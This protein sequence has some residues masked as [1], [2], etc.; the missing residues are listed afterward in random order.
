LVTEKPTID[1]QLRDDLVA[2]L[3]APDGCPWDR[4]QRLTDLRAYLLEEAHEVASAID[5]ESWNDL[6]EEMGDLLFQLAFLGRL[7]EEAG[8]F[9]LSDSISTVHDKMVERHPHVFASRSTSGDQRAPDKEAVA[10]DWERR[11]VEQ[12]R[13]G[14]SLL[15]GVNPSLPSLLS[16]YRM[17]QKA[18]GV[19]FDWSRADDVIEKVREELAELEEARFES[20]ERSFEEIGDLLFAVANLARHL[21]VDP[22]A[23]LARSNLKFRRRFGFIEKTLASEERKLTDASLEEL[24]ALWEQAKDGEVAEPR[25]PR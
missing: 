5:R 21:D 9:G 6:R 14:D 12:R 10:K 18:A 15:E 13:T 16:S 24:E 22:E 11:K 19:G 23:A 20:K 1:M 4:E 17:T 25:P 2:R 8:R 7:N 3:R